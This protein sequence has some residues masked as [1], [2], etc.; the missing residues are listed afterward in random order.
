MGI[1]QRLERMK[2]I[3]SIDDRVCIVWARR[4]AGDRK[5]RENGHSR[6]G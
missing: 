3:E 6:L 2:R 4:S 5:K 1:V